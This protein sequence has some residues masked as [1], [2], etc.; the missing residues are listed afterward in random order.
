MRHATLVMLLVALYPGPL[1]AQIVRG[2]VVDSITGASLA[3]SVVFLTSAD[4]AEADRTTTDNRGF[5]LLRAPT[6]WSYYLVAVH[7]GYRHSIFPPFDLEAER[8]RSF[9]LIVDFARC[10]SGYAQSAE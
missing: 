10:G 7:E 1:S 8:M 2:Q 9:V 4:G 5:F 6:R 3:R